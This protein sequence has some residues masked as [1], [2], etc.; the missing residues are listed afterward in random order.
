M[1]LIVEDGTG[2]DNADSYVSRA[3]A[4]TYVTNH[5]NESEWTSASDD[6]KD[7]AL[8][9]ATA[10]LDGRYAGRWKGWRLRGNLQA[11]DWPRDN[12]IDNEGYYLSYDELPAEIV[13]ATIVAAVTHLTSSTPLN[14]P[15]AGG[16]IAAER[17]K[18]GEL[19]HEVKYASS[20]QTELLSIP[21]IDR[22]LARHGL[23]TV[24]SDEYS[25]G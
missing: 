11:L 2:L 10:W 17:S 6:D 14:A 5:G 23:L 16:T 12:V 19:E 24:S 7:R 15:N 9:I 1:A 13:I 18:V 22:L 21:E 8:R 3:D 20:E 25:R 4:D